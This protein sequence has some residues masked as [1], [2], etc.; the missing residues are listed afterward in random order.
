MDMSGNLYDRVRPQMDPESLSSLRILTSP[1][2]VLRLT[3][4]VAW[5][6]VLSVSEDLILPSIHQSVERA[7]ETLTGAILAFMSLS[8]PWKKVALV[9]RA[10]FILNSVIESK[11]IHPYHLKHL[12]GLMRDVHAEF[13]DH[14]D[15]EPIVPLLSILVQI[16]RLLAENNQR[17][18]T[19]TTIVLATAKEG[20]QTIVS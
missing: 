19:A 14:K 16:E 15:M 8:R 3:E 13:P 2:T 12:K 20:T 7:K 5:N 11:G 4:T 17:P 9:L 6:L 10:I 1:S 18:V